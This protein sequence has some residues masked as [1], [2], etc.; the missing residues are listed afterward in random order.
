MI[1]CECVCLLL[2]V[3]IEIQHSLVYSIHSFLGLSIYLHIVMCYVCWYILVGQKYV[4]SCR[5]VS[6]ITNGEAYT[7]NTYNNILY[8]S[9]IQLSTTVSPV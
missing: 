3:S 7:K 4:C 1:K 2:D 6:K 9:Y 5:V 8:T